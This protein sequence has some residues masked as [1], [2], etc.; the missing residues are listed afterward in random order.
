MRG[1]D[2]ALLATYTSTVGGDTLGFDATN[3]GDA[4]GDG[5]VDF[6]LTSAWSSVLGTNTGR[7]FVVAGPLPTDDD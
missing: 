4:D 6:L 1:R 7:V 2:G 3:V 5:G